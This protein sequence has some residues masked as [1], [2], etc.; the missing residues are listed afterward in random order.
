M[1]KI[2]FIGIYLAMTIVGNSQNRVVTGTVSAFNDL[3]LQNIQ[4]EAKKSGAKVA[5]DS[6]GSFTIVC[7]ERDVLQFSSQSFKSKNVRLKKKTQHINV[8]LYFEGNQDDIEQ[9]VGYG[10]M[11]PNDIT[12]A[13]SFLNDNNKN[14]CSYKDIFEL[15][16]GKCPGVQIMNIGRSEPSVVIRGVSSITSDYTALYV[17]DGMVVNS[18]SHI[19]PCFVK[20]ISF[21]KDGSASIY[22]SRGSGGVVLI[23]TIK[24]TDR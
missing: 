7:N 1:K 15:I 4:V 8:Y 10:Y 12:F 24:A 5:T 23:E 19:P 13:V 6:M 14:F 20:N 16:K 2:L 22:G 17:V 3:L 21:L 11:K 18:I 9:A